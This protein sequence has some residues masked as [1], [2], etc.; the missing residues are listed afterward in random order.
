MIGDETGIVKLLLCDE[1]TGQMSMGD[2]VRIDGGYVTSFC[3]EIQLNAG[4][5]CQLIILF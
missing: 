3:G 5:Y 2:K 1:K 4:K